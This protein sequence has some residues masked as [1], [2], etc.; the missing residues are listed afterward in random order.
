[1]HAT[2]RTV[3]D[4]GRNRRVLSYL[5]ARSPGSA[6]FQR[7]EAAPDPFLGS[8]SHP[9]IVE[10]VWRGLAVSLPVDCR[11]LVHGT[12][13]LVQPATGLV[14]AVAIGTQYALRLRAGDVATAM[15]RGAA[16][17]TRWG[18]GDAFDVRE[19]LGADWRLGGW[20]PEEPAWIGA[21][22]VEEGGRR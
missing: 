12:P 9:D 5:A 20:M 7:P 4:E 6:A 17:R 19:A 22:F 3:T 21:C 1:M 14:L 16:T 11:A 15:A 10:R 2:A 18:G 13:A 8:G